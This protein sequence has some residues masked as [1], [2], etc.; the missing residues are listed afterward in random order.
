MDTKLYATGG[1][2]RK[3]S[4]GALITLSNFHFQGIFSENGDSL[5]IRSSDWDISSD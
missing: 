4:T 2:S 5:T 3:W 1:Y